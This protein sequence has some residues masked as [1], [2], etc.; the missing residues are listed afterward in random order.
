MVFRSTT[1]RRSSR[2]EVPKVL[3]P[4]DLGGGGVAHDLV[5]TGPHHP[6]AYRPMPDHRDEV[7]AVP[8]LPEGVPLGPERPHQGAAVGVDDRR[9]EP[10]G[11]VVRHDVPPLQDPALD[12]FVQ[13]DEPRRDD[14]SRRV[15]HPTGRGR[16]EAPDR[17]D[18]V[19]P[20]AD[21]G[22]VPGV[23]RAVENPPVP[24]DHVV[25]RLLGG[26]G[27]GEE[28]GQGQDGGNAG[29]HRGLSCQVTRPALTVRRAR[30]ASS[31]SS[32]AVTG[33]PLQVAES[34]ERVLACRR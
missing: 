6:F 24:D 21:V 8:Q 30:R 23:A 2:P 15:D 7:E 20:D 26:S 29:H 10:L 25:G 16:A 31:E 17:H 32:G 9:R 3:H 4:R 5:R 13:A 12:V 33:S 14:L 1:N 18:P 34:P 27:R 11:E 28:D 22:L 19:A